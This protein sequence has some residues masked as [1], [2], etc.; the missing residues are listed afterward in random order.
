M[1]TLQR[2]KEHMRLDHDEWDDLLND[3]LRS[4]TIRAETLTG[5]KRDDFNEMINNAIIT[6]IESEFNSGGPHPSSIA[7]YRQNSIRPMF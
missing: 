3:L 1:I 4:A 5:L 7:V 6:D 2:I